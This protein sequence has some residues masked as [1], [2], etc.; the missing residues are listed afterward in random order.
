MIIVTYSSAVIIV[1]PQLNST[2]QIPI[3]RC[4]T[5]IIVNTIAIR[6]RLHAC[7][8]NDHDHDTNT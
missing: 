8:V 3:A 6:L 1:L 4:A 5:L 2:S 7:S